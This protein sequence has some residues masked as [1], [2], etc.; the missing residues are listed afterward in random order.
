MLGV[1]STIGRAFTTDPV[2]EACVGAAVEAA[3]SVLQATGG[4]LAAVT[5]T[6]V[7]TAPAAAVAAAMPTA[8]ASS[9][10]PIVQDA[11]PASVEAQKP[12]LSREEQMAQEMAYCVKQK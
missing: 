3:S 5:G 12:Q 2:G 1:L 10:A 4:N 11:P 6:T 8:Q 9:P 7:T